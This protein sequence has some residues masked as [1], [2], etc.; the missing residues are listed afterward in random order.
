MGAPAHCGVTGGAVLDREG[1]REGIAEG[2][3]ERVFE[4]SYTTRDGGTGLGLAMVHHC[5][6]E[7]HGGRVSLESRR[8]EGTRVRLLLPAGEAAT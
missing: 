2:D 1:G 4:F 3:R 5:I 8:G 6:V 7:E